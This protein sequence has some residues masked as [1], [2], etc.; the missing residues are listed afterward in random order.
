M[1]TILTS[2]SSGAA[3]HVPPIV[4]L[5]DDDRD[6][7]EMYSMFFESSGMCVATAANPGEAMD[8][9]EQLQPDVVVT[10]IGFGVM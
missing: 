1:L 10:D 4:L 8:A 5:V 9:V 7:R 3:A 6:T 2:P